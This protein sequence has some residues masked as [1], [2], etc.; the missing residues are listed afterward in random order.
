[1]PILPLPP[2]PS[3]TFE[4]LRAVVKRVLAHV[5]GVIK[6]FLT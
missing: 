5:V 3:L 2:T 4:R 1:M 6:Y